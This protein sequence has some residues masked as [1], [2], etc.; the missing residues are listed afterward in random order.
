MRVNELQPVHCEEIPHDLDYGV[1]YI[2]RLY[3]VA[4]HLCACGCDKK[5]VTP[6]DAKIG[7]TID[8]ADGKITLRPSIGN[9]RGEDPYHAHYFITQNTIQWC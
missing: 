3:N 4:V 9:F 5:T 7:W 1:L 8:D 6:L 2:S